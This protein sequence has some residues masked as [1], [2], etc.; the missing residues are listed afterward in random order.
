MLFDLVPAPRGSPRGSGRRQPLV[1]DNDA[2]ESTGGSAGSR[3]LMEPT[4]RSRGRATDQ[5][6]VTLE[7]LPAAVESAAQTRGTRWI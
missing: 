2:S 5:F 6:A 7:V 4:A 1:T 3:Y